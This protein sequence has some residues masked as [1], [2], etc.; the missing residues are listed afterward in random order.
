MKDVHPSV[1]LLA[2]KETTERLSQSKDDQ[3]KM[4]AEIIEFVIPNEES[5]VLANVAAKSW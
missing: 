4:E 1:I 2:S 3:C 5:L